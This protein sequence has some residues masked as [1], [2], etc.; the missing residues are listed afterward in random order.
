MRP[1]D[2]YERVLW[3]DMKIMFEPDIKS[4]VWRNLQ[5]YK[6]TVWKLFVSALELPVLKTRD[7]DLWSM[8][9][10]QYLTH[11]D[12]ALSEVIV[13]GD[14]PAI[15]STSAAPIEVSWNQGCKDLMGSIKA[16]SEG[17]ENTSSTNEVVNTSHEVST[18]SSQG[19]ASSSTY[20]DEIYTDGHEEMDLK[21]D[22]GH[23]YHEGEKILKEDMK[24]SEFQWQ[25]NYWLR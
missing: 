23:A 18:A 11:T 19:Q 8:R 24:E 21:M 16:R 4:E 5:V 25:I 10:E 12:Y 20:A 17:L 6:V 7:Y 3:G 22:G 13:N 9:I 1:E 15:A 14:A 2:E